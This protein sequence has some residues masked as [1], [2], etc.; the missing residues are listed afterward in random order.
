M[1]SGAPVRR[2]YSRMVGAK[3]PP[4]PATSGGWNG[5]FG[6]SAHMVFDSDCFS[7][8]TVSTRSWMPAWTRLAATTAVEPPTDP[9][10]CTRISG[11]PAAPRASAKYSSGIITPSN[12]SGALPTTTASTFAYPIPASASARS[13]ASRT[14]PA[15]DRSWRAVSCLV[16]PIPIT[17][18]RLAMC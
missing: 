8:A 1:C 10:V 2:M 17:A 16:C 6:A 15:I 14:S 9:A 5:I 18:H 12:M 13:A 7:N 3:Y 4:A 11:L